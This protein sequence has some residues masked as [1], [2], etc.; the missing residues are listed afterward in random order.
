M[1]IDDKKIIKRE[2]KWGAELDIEQQQK[3]NI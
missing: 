2:I 1:Q 3:L